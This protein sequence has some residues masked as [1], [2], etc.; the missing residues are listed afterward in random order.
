LS[1]RAASETARGK[2]SLAAL[3]ENQL[4]HVEWKEIFGVEDDDGTA[5]ESVKLKCVGVVGQQGSL[6]TDLVD[7]LNAKPSVVNVGVHI[8][9]AG[10]ACSKF[11][12]MPVRSQLSSTFMKLVFCQPNSL[13]SSLFLPSAF[14]SS[15]GELYAFCQ[16]VR[17]AAERMLHG[18]YVLVAHQME[19]FVYS[20]FRIIPSEILADTLTYPLACCNACTYMQADASNAILLLH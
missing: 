11:D 4:E 7:C 8:V 10:T 17:S 3:A 13:N 2:R 15:N 20:S 16:H 9:S 12:I 6:A 1:C 19:R 18:V 5:L 14:L